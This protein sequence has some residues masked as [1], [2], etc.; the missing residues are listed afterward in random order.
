MRSL[1][2]L[3]AGAALGTA[4]V[5]CDG[6]DSPP[7]PDPDDPPADAA[8]VY[9]TPTQHLT[10]ASLALRGIR[11]SLEELRAVDADPGKLPAIVDRYLASP[12][13]GET[14]RDLHNETL[15]LRAEQ[16]FLTFP[17]IGGLTGATAS[18]I[19]GAVLEEPLRLIED[20]V[21]SDQPYTK[22]VTADYT[23]AD[24]VVAEIWGL[25]HTGPANVWQRQQWPDGR[26]AAGVLATSVLYHRHRST[27]F[28]FNRGRANLISSA[29]LCHDFL[30]S[31]IQID[32]S[33]DLSDPD[34]VANAV[35]QNQ[36]CAGCHQAMDPLASYLFPFRGQV[37]VGNITAYPVPYY[38]PDQADRWQTTN[39]RPPHY[40]GQQA[41]GLAGLGQAIAG[42]PRFARCT[43]QRF[44]SY[45]T[46]VAPRSLPGAWIARLQKVLEGSNFSAKQL[47]KAIVLSDEFRVSHHPDADAAEHLVG[48][49]K[50]RPEQLSRML[51][52]LTGFAWTTTSTQ[53]LRG[54]P[55]GQADLLK[56]DFI[57]FRVLG[58]GIDSF[59]VTEPVHTMNATSSLV[60]R[61]A[62]AAAADFVVAHDATAPAGERRLFVEAA[63][64][65]AAEP[66]VRAQLAYLHGRIYG[67]L[68]GPDSPEVDETYQL[69]TEVLAQAS[70]NAQRAWR[71]TLIGMLSDFRSLFY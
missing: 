44:A 70:G 17:A 54:I 25:P 11:P 30:E 40:F 66:A 8:V 15:L 69:F 31:D 32:T 65:D 41:S 45:M 50:L 43:A 9:L 5:A 36:A 38:L 55:Y 60:A 24:G 58:G 33:V 42:D 46:E 14:I 62:A 61:A 37:G 39:K 1:A 3:L 12:A 51:R 26:G 35:V 34:V 4:L 2:P 48:T 16:G 63:V 19:N 67:E 7:T 29:F 28:N 20:I 56:S 59:F 52:G 71:L 49:L 22:I 6:T 57:G 47:A 13:F 23:M 27:G 64:D 53:Q 18:R 68:V 10:R 21:M